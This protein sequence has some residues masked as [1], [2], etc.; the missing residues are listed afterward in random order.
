MSK[1]WQRS[2]TTSNMSNFSPSKTTTKHNIYDTCTEFS[3]DMFDH[4]SFVV[5]KLPSS[6]FLPESQKPSHPRRDESGQQITWGWS[7]RID[8][9]WLRWCGDSE[10]TRANYPG[11]ALSLE[12]LPCWTKSLNRRLVCIA[13]KSS[14]T[15]DIHCSEKSL[16][17]RRNSTWRSVDHTVSKIMMQISCK[18]KKEN[19]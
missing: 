12:D 4:L 17:E 5:R 11:C 1:K 13:A 16:P 7:R 14:L 19:D 18:I 10:L 9:Q 3:T 2:W 8:N 6:S 15:W